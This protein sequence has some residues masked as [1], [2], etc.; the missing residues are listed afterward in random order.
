MAKKASQEPVQTLIET[1]REFNETKQIDETTLLGVLEGIV[2]KRLRFHKLAI[3]V[4]KPHIDSISADIH[5]DKIAGI[6]I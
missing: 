3:E 1:F 4:D 6:G 2:A 5:T